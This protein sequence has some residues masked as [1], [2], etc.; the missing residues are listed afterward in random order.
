M[1]SSTE[2]PATAAPAAPAAPAEAPVEV[3][4]NLLTGFN[5]REG[6]SAVELPDCASLADAKQAA[7]TASREKKCPV[8]A[9]AAGGKFYLVFRTPLP[10]GLPRSPAT[11][12]ALPPRAAHHHPTGNEDVPALKARIA[13]L[14]A[15]VSELTDALLRALPGAPSANVQPAQQQSRS[16]GQRRRQHHQH[17]RQ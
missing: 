5:T 9:W 11:S 12:R 2:A 8:L 13:E 3:P 6:D 17:Q 14:E 7:L 1:S 4:L 16:G 15:K 10:T